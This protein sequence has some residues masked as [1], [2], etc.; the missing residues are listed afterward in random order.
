MLPSQGMRSVSGGAGAVFTSLGG[1]CTCCGTCFQR[2]PGPFQLGSE[3]REPF[4]ASVCFQVNF[5]RWSVFFFFFTLYV[6]VLNDTPKKHIASLVFLLATL[7]SAF[8]GTEAG[9]T[10]VWGWRADLLT[11][12]RQQGRW[13]WTCVKPDGLQRGCSIPISPH[14]RL[15]PFRV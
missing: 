3:G 5:F 14:S 13:P 2:Q 12:P 11:P 8:L 6:Y 1:E 10:A 4:A 15:A 7:S 9:G